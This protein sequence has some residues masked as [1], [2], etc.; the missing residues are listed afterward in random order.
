MANNQSNLL[1]SIIYGV[2]ISLAAGPIVGVINYLY[3][4]IITGDIFQGIEAITLLTVASFMGAAG[5][6]V[7]AL[8]NPKSF[9][10]TDWWCYITFVATMA[11]YL[12]TGSILIHGISVLV[13][14]LAVDVLR[15]QPVLFHLGL[16]VYGFLLVTIVW[17]V[18][19]VIK[20]FK[21]KT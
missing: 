18:I 17:S 10:K 4:W 12:A 9:P 16:Q 3:Q 11:T 13:P 19:C 8:L 15:T 21:N 14:Q 1:Q 2:F 20:R 6:I 5:G 7:F